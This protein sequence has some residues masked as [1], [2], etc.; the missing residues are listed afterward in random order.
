ML[1]VNFITL[2]NA[3]SH[4]QIQPQNISESQTD[5]LQLQKVRAILRESPLID[6]HNDTP[7]QYMRRVNYDL[8]RLDLTSDTAMQRN[9]VR[10]D[11]KRLRAGC[12][13]A[14][15]WAIFIP[16]PRNGEENIVK[17]VLE[18][19]D[20]VHRMIERHADSLEFAQTADDIVRIHRSGKIASLIGVEGGHAIDNSLAVLRMY[21]FCG[22]RY[23]TLTHSHY[24]DWADSSTDEPVHKGLT[25]FGIEVIKEMNRLGMLVDL[26]H[27]SD[28]T[29]RMAMDISEAPVIFSHS[30]A[31]AVCDAP[32]NLP[33]DLLKRIPQNGGIIMVN[34]VPNYVADDYDKEEKLEERRLEQAFPEQR[35]KAREEMRN[36][37]H[38]RR[39]SEVKLPQVADHID[40]I[41]KVAGIDHIGI[42]SDFEGFGRSITGLEDVSCFPSFLVELM[43]RGYTDDDIR[44]IAGLNFLRVLREAEKTAQRLQSK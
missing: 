4:A 41:R 44:K 20:F 3:V 33:D 34:F 30:C 22:A 43:K 27:T 10:T 40:H 29:V 15:F 17:S 28:D 18:Q 24:N 42:G 36:W 39:P 32:R 11:L 8:D 31:R 12:L 21:Y 23:M 37:R 1:A 7:W 5:D 38:S 2:A 6:G 25:P 35:E 9:P 14:Q 13:G 19:I 16:P 26:S